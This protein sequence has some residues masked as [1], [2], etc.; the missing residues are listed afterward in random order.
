MPRQKF[1]FIVDL[2]SLEILEMNLCQ[3]IEA[4][5]KFLLR[6]YREKNVNKSLFFV[7]S[8]A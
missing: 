3:R 7:L 2:S 5:L 8:H 4:I 6:R 1:V